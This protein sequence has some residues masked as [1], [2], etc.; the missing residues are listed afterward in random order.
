MKRETIR[1]WEKKEYTYPMAYGFIPKLD[2]YLHE[3][4]KKRPGMIVVPGGGY[5]MVSPTEG[6]PVALKFYDQG[7]QVFV[8]TYT[9]DFLGVTPLRLQPVKDLARAVRL[10]RKYGNIYDLTD[11]VVVCGFSAGGHAVGTLCVHGSG[12]PEENPDYR[13]I[14]CRP[15]AVI[16]SYPVIT[17]ETYTHADSSEVLLGKDASPEEKD[18]FSLEKHV[19]VDSPPAFIWQ[20]A[21]DELVPVENSALYAEACKHAGVPFAYHV[22]SKGMH[23]LS[24]GDETVAVTADNAYTSEQVM[25]MVEAAKDGVL[26]L[27]EDVMQQLLYVEEMGKQYFHQSKQPSRKTVKNEEVA[28]WIGLASMWLRELLNLEL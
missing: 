14:S 7:Y 24:V 21:A 20:T 11:I 25:T 10:L 2:A 1:L 8:C 19:T 9:T 28:S 6:E 18:Y 23:G 12:V 5:R 17:M 4:R 26:Q 15:D 3:D 27:P 13:N 16:L 22:F